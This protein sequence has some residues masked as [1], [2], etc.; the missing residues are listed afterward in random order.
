MR[1]VNYEAFLVGGDDGS[2]RLGDLDVGDLAVIVNHPDP[3]HVGRP[4]LGV[5]GGGSFV[6]V[7][8]L[9]TCRLWTPLKQSD[10]W[11]RRLRPGEVVELRAK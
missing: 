1:A 9:V 7:V 4:V 10:I 3:G 6:N 11:V 5:D 8:N 2:A